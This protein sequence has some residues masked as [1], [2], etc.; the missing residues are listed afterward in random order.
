MSDWALVFQYNSLN[1]LAKLD[2]PIQKKI[3]SYLKGQV[4]ASGNPPA[5]WKAA[6]RSIG[7]I[8]AVPRHGLPN[9]VFIRG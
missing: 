5:F 4:I 8:L 9:T 7:L 2:K 1:E 3:M 6:F